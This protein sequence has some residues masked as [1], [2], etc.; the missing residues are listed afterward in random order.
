[1]HDGW[2][3]LHTSTDAANSAP[4]GLRSRM[5]T[6]AIAVTKRIH[7]DDRALIGT[8]IQAVD[9]VARRCDELANRLAELEQQLGDVVDVL[10]ADLTR[11][12]A[13]LGDLADAA[14]DKTNGAPS[15]ADATSTRGSSRPNG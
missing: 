11:V 1:M 10:G 5:D 12:R 9:A 4:N 2:A 6:I 14:S 8:V 15:V 13:V 3:R 7:H